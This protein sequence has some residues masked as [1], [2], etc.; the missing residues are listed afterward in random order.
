[1]RLS[2]KGE[3]GLLA[4]IDLAL[5]YGHGPIQSLQIAERQRI[6][7]QY[8]DQLM[9]ILRKAG[10]VESS[11]GRQGGYQLAR[12]PKEITLYDIV[13]ELEGPV[14]NI[15]F[16]ERSPHRRTPAREVFRDIWTDLYSNTVQILRSKTIEEFCERHRKLEQEIM[17]YI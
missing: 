16:L 1:M 4:V 8:L 5:H 6:P 12:P 9:L 10:I 17:Y 14:E 7:K 11:R 13:R 15:N 2:T 3:Y